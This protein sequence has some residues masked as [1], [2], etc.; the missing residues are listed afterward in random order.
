MKKYLIS[1]FLSGFTS[2]A[3]SQVPYY[4]PTD[5][6]VAWYPFNGNANDE[7][8]NGYNGVVNSSTNLTTDRCGLINSA[9]Y[10][11]GQ[12]SRITIPYSIFNGGWNAHT[13][14]CWIN[15]DTLLNPYNGIYNQSIINTD[16]HRGEE[17]CFN[18]GGN[19]KYHFF[20]GSYPP[21]GIWDIFGAPTSSSGNVVAN[22]WTHVAIVKDGTS[23]SFYINGVL[24][25]IFETNIIA[26]S[27]YCQLVIG[28]I[29][30]YAPETFFGKLDDFGIW[31]RALSDSEIFQIY[32]VGCCT[33]GP[34]SVFSASDSLLC[35]ASCINFIDQSANYPASWQWIFDG[36]T[37]AYSSDQNPGTVCYNAPGSYAV[38]LIT[39]NGCGSDTDILPNFITVYPLPNQP[40]ITQTNDTLTSSSAIGYQWFINGNLIPGS[41]SQSIVINQTGIYTV[42]IF[43]SEGCTS[44]ADIN[45]PSLLPIDFH[46]SNFVLCEK[47]CTD[48]LDESINSPTAWYWQFPGGF[49][50][51]SSDQNPTNICYSNPGT[52]DVTL[53]TS[54]ASG[55]DTL[56]LQ[57]Y[58]IVNST[59]PVPIIT[60]NGNTLT[61]S[62]AAGYQWQFNLV[63]IP[64]ATNQSYDT[65]QTGYY[66]VLINDL[67][68]CYS[69]ASMYIL[70]EGTEDISQHNYI[71]IYPNPSN[72]KF[73]IEAVTDAVI[74][75]VT[76][77]IL[78]QLGQTVYFFDKTMNDSHFTEKINLE[79]LPLGIYYLK[80]NTDNV[81]A[82]RKFI[83]AE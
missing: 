72:G 63:N 75:R 80:L 56:T 18:C 7:S 82:K 70:V 53:I 23:Y 47:F 6:L 4:I 73:T 37:P 52:Y 71:A 26:T 30:Q 5:S 54:G 57:N 68:G 65:Q 35:A 29:S 34:A 78:N 40:V 60:Q 13:I 79:T 59:P 62:I 69:S 83:I 43:D 9:Y 42:Q 32:N 24:D 66:T 19:G 77:E 74:G 76:I 31:K 45:V 1:L 16:P 48:Y 61:S 27:Y 51:T 15:S 11:N 49:P 41:T 64:G 46:A 17:I 10:F 39:T 38:T 12:N 20:A 28:T 33:I 67:N 50:P 81:N 58:I 2:Y 14:C 8:G 36:A 21:A 22:S 25:T 44:S 3:F 55:S